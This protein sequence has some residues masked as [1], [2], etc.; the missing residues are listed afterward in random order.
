MWSDV[1]DLEEFYG[2]TLGQM[3]ARL[4]RARLREVWPSVR[5]ES[6]LGLGYATPL[7]RP[8][9]EP[10]GALTGQV[11]VASR[12]PPFPTP[13]IGFCRFFHK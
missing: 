5:G 12:L 7:L 10:G 2:S 11:A 6:V 3:T 4:L 9:V 8:F 1:L 13:L